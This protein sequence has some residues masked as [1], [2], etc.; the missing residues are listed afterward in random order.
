M[1]GAFMKLFVLILLCWKV[2]ATEI[3]Q[4]AETCSACHGAQGISPNELWP[5]LAGQKEKYLLHELQDFRE[6]SRV[7]PLMSPVSKT[8]SD[9]DMRELA[10]YFAQLK[11][12]P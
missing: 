2:G 11:G 10:A 7:D 3:K 5:N 4:K 8:L 9:Q 1:K 6:G 12:A